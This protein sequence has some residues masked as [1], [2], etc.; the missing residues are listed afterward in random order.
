MADGYEEQNE[1]WITWGGLFKYTAGA[2]ATVALA[3]YAPAAIG[4]IG[5]KLGSD[6]STT[7][8]WIGEKLTGASSG[9]A[10]FYGTVVDNIDTHHLLGL[11][12]ATVENGVK[13]FGTVWSDVLGP[14]VSNLWHN[15][16]NGPEYL[17]KGSGWL[18]YPSIA[19]AAV[20]GGKWLLNKMADKSDEVSWREREEARR[21]VAGYNAMPPYA[22]AGVRGGGNGGMSYADMETMREARR[23]L[24][25]ANGQNLAGA[26]SS[27]G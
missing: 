5:E 8:G 16:V 20:V 12:K 13:E 17:G 6:T 9:L 21:Q 14:G 26:Q 11:N 23:R 1:S 27:P 10:T 18:T 3:S 15:F 25:M 2:I 22:G 4:F 24:A 19:L 7:L